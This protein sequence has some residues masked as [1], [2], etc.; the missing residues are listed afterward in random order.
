MG[1]YTEIYIC[2]EIKDDTPDSVLKVI[3][4]LFDGKQELKDWE[5]LELPA[6]EFFKTD[7]WRIIGKCCS[8]YHIPFATSDLRYDEISKSYHLVSRSDLKN[9][10]GE[11]GL[12]FD[13]IMPYLD[14][15]EGE[16]IGYSRYEENDEPKLYFKVNAH[17]PQH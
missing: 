2:S 1:M 14:K 7:R 3:Q 15:Y 10:D 8:Y 17:H 9:Y 5:K 13:W 6:H 12:F 16:F 11:I 4:Y